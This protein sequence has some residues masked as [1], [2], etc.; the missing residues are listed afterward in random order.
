M[1]DIH[2]ELDDELSIKVRIKIAKLGWIKGG[3]SQAIKE[4][5][6]EWVKKNE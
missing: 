6:E 5:L 4:A 2:F 3:L 1:V